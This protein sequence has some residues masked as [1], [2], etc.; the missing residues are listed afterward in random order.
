[1]DHAPSI[2]AEANSE[3]QIAPARNVASPPARLGDDPNSKK[4]ARR[5]EQ[6]GFTIR[7]DPQQRSFFESLALAQGHRSIAAA[8]KAHALSSGMDHPLQEMQL[9]L[10]HM[11]ERISEEGAWLQDRIQSMA[12]ALDGVNQHVFDVLT[13]MQSCTQ[14]MVIFA[15]TNQALAAAVSSVRSPRTL[16]AAAEPSSTK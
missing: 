3:P 11:Q 15:Q 2:L 7:L 14:A 9:S 13:E 12:H 5:S 10:E 1:M 6:F 4:P 8:F 16:H